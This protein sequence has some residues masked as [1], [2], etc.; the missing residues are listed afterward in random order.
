MA[1]IAAAIGGSTALVS[2]QLGSH[3]IFTGSEKDA[4]GWGDSIVQWVGCLYCT[5]LTQAQ[6]SASHMVG[7]SGVIPECCASSN[8]SITVWPQ[9]Q[10][11][12]QKVKNDSLTRDTLNETEN[13]AFKWILIF[14]DY[15]VWKIRNVVAYFC[16]KHAN[17]LGRKLSTN[18]QASLAPA[19]FFI[20]CAVYLKVWLTWTSVT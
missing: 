2:N 16:C 20:G 13:Y 5:K 4:G 8:L 17:C 1:A 10:N 6:S 19:W 3:C 18:G 9:N 11:K 12:A 14:Q 15:P 7:S